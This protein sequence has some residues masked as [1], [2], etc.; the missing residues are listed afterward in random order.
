MQ[1]EP[2]RSWLGVLGR[3]VRWEAKSYT[4]IWAI[5][6]AGYLCCA[7]AFPLIDGWTR[8]GAFGFA[9]MAAPWIGTGTGLSIRLHGRRN[10]GA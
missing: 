4:Q 10:A 6:A 3:V 8:Q 5:C 9:G 7:I 2:G 1:D